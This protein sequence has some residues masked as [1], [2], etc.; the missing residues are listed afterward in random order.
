MHEESES[1]SHTIISLSPLP[2]PTRLHPAKLP[3]PPE[4]MVDCYF[5]TDLAEKSRVLGRKTILR[6]RYP[7]TMQPAPNTTQQCPAPPPRCW[8]SGSVVYHESLSRRALTISFF[9]FDTRAPSV[10]HSPGIGEDGS[11]KFGSSGCGQPLGLCARG[12]VW[13]RTDGCLAQFPYLPGH[14]AVLFLVL[15]Q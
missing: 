4:G 6:R 12:A 3:Q 15:G 8:G 13:D 10:L 5:D 9:F 11:S 1:L 14:D 7:C 2:E